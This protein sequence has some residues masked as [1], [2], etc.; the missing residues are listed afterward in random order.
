[1]EVGRSRPLF[2]AVCAAAVAKGTPSLSDSALLFSV[3]PFFPVVAGVARGR[4]GGFRVEPPPSSNPECSIGYGLN[5]H[6]G[7]VTFDLERGMRFDG[8]WR[9]ERAAIGTTEQNAQPFF[10]PSSCGL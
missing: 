9:M 3:T 8:L 10:F 1:M 6:V 4:R 2:S 5:F 7:S